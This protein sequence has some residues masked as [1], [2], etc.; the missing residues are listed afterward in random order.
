MNDVDNPGSSSPEPVVQQ[1]EC[2]LQDVRTCALNGSVFAV[3]L[4]AGYCLFVG[5]I[6][7]EFNEAARC[8]A[9]RSFSDRTVRDIAQKLVE[10]R[11]RGKIAT[12]YI[13][14]FRLTHPG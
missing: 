8:G 10:L 2:P 1:P 11:V 9:N 4:R 3:S 6:K 14:C 12:K 13:L 7:V 5:W